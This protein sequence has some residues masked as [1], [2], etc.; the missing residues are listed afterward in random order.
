MEHRGIPPIAILWNWLNSVFWFGMGRGAVSFTGC[1]RRRDESSDNRPI[2]P[3]NRPTRVREEA[4]VFG[5]SSRVRRLGVSVGPVQGHSEIVRQSSENPGESSDQAVPSFVARGGFRGPSIGGF[6]GAVYG[7]S[8]ACPA[9]SW[10]FFASDSDAGRSP[11]GR[12]CK[13][14]SA[15]AVLS[16]SPANRAEAWWGAGRIKEGRFRAAGIRRWR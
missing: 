11:R 10:P 16:R 1:A 4:E 2:F 15:S 14:A 3:C 12:L 8:G 7:E 6:E 5:F 13:G 9:D